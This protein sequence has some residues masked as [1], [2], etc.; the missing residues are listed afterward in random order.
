MADRPFHWAYLITHR[1]EEADWLN[2]GPIILTLPGPGLRTDRVLV[3]RFV[4]A[5][6][7]LLGSSVCVKGQGTWQRSG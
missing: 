4:F 6:G 3:C 5:S 1:M 2:S 7:S